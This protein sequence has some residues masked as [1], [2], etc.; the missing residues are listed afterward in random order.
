MDK[1][2]QEFREYAIKLNNSVERHIVNVLTFMINFMR[3]APKTPECKKK[4]FA[5]Y[6]SIHPF[7][8]IIK[9]DNQNGDCKNHELCTVINAFE[10]A[11][12]K[13]EQRTKS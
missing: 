7:Y 12:N 3:E 8:D 9:C 13:V 5:V 1:T 11:T 6:Q 2:I 10:E 4:M